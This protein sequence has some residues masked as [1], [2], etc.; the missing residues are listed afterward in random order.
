MNNG[1]ALGLIEA[2]GLTAAAA[3]LDAAVKA[4]EV[5]CIG[6]EKIIGVNKQIS[7]TINLEGDV[8]AV[9]AAVESG[10]EAGNKVGTVVSSRVI[11]SPHGDV[12]KLVGLFRPN[13][14]VK[15]AAEESKVE[16]SVKTEVKDSTPAP[17]VENA[18]DEN[19]KK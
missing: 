16:K 13:K 11:P 17:V 12:K 1:M 3:A 6:V 10:V 14:V 2:I 15:V 19:K 18:Y 7:V 5:K 4:A 9:Q 8:G